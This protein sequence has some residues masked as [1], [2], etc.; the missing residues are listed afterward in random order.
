MKPAL[1]DIAV[2]IL[3]FNRPKQLEAVFRQVCQARPSRL[4]LYQDGPRNENDLP[5]I[6]ACREVVA[7]IDW[8]CEVHQLYQEKNYGCDPSEFISQ[9]WAFSLADKCIVLEDDDVPALSFFP[10]CKE[11]LDK[12]E[13]D[14]RIS[15]IAGFNPE[16]VSPD[17][18]YDYFFASTF[19]IWG[20][21]SWKRVVDQWDEHYSFLDDSFNM[22]QLQQL[23]KERKYRDD[24]IY[25]CQR[26]RENG[27]AYYETIFHASMLF[28]S[29]LAIVPTHNMI[30]NLGVT[31]DS[32][33]FAGSVHTLPRAY[34]RI[35]TMQRHELTFPL[36]HPRYVIENVAYKQSVYRIMCWG[37]PWRKVARSLEELFLNLRYGNFRLIGQAVRKRWAKWMKQDKHL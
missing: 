31:S 26:H 23:I 9:K 16:E 8:E 13:H 35:F 30:N 7:Q 22:R 18:P 4:F 6:Q 5:G 37:H 1:V 3:F 11:M 12:Y 17:V 32:T 2:L 21:A 15:M 24:F 27:K 34:R 19:S 25:M 28:N 36:K 29:G 20:W 10:F 14:T 33:H